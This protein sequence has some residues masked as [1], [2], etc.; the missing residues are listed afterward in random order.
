MQMLREMHKIYVNSKDVKGTFSEIMIG[1]ILMVQLMD[2]GGL[3]GMW[4]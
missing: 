1:M 4:I 3:E 2:D